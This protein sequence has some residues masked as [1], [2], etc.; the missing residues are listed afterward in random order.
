MFVYV[1]A[2]YPATR[3]GAEQSESVVWDMIIPATATPWSLTN[4]K[5]TYFPDKKTLRATKNRNKKGADKSK[6]S[7]T[8]LTL[9][10]R[11]SLKNQ[12]PKYQ[13]T[14]PTGLMSERSNVT[15]QVSWNV[16]PWVGA[17][18]W[19][20]GYLGS[21]VGSWKAGRA[22]RSKSFDLPALKGSKPEV[23][24]DTD[25]SKMPE[26]GEGKPLTEI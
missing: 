6:G 23:V 12:K 2:N 20:R 3:N 4:L 14:D 9:P 11:I 16:Q 25:G 5:N 13:I 26:A 21:R 15:L 18:V 24:K 7:T 17:L 10:G 22:G 1:T 19:D 8:A